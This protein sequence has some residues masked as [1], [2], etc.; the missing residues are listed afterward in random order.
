[1]NARDPPTGRDIAIGY[2]RGCIKERAL[3]CVQIENQALNKVLG[4][5][6]TEIVNLR[7]IE[8]PWDED[9]CVASGCPTNIA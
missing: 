1:D 3:E 2:L 7:A 4:Q 6:E 5:P 9:W 8:G